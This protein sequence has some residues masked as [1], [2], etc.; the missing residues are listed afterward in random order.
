M[1]KIICAAAL[2]L[3]TLA[4]CCGNSR[5]AVTKQE[6]VRV[7]MHHPGEYS[8]LVRDGQTIKTDRLNYGSYWEYKAII[9][10]DVLEKEPM[11]YELRNKIYTIH[12]HSEKDV[13]GG[14]YK[15]GKQPEVN[16]RVVK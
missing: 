13:D 3:V 6:V 4:G 7:F 11:W 8:A 5:P 15:P 12:L 16:T 9:V 14:A 2:A 10:L 1:R